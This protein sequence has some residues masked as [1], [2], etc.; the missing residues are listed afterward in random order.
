M[1][2]YELMVI[3]KPQQ[4]TEDGS[5]VKQNIEKL[6]TQHKGKIL[7]SDDWGEKTLATPIEGHDRGNYVV[8]TLEMDPGQIQKFR[9]KMNLDKDLLRYLLLTIKT[10]KKSD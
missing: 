5:E 2:H 9:E 3:F 1:N 10:K 7:T 4:V 6:L 8:Y